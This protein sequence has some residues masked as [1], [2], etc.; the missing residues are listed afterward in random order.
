M[1]DQRFAGGSPVAGHDVDDSDGQAN[2]LAISGVI[3]APV[4]GRELGWLE[5][6]AVFPGGD[7]AGAIFQASMSSAE[8]SRE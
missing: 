1:L 7:G 6:R 5:R 4:S 2:F 3:T 8:N